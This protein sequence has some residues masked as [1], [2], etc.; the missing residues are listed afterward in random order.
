MCDNGDSVSVPL[1]FNSNGRAKGLEKIPKHSFDLKWFD[2]KYIPSSQIELN[3][4]IMV[5]MMIMMAIVRTTSMT[6]Q[7]GPEIVVADTCT[8]E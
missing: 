4:T 1:P 2:R 5:M 7:I 3:N 8:C 6:V